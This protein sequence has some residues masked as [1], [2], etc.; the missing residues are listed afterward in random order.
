MNG[1]IRSLLNLLPYGGGGDKIFIFIMFIYANRRLPRRSSCLAN[2]YFYFLKNSSDI[3]DAYRQL[4]SDKILVKE[5]IEERVDSKFIVKTLGIF[6]SIDQ[7]DVR[8]LSKP[9]VLKPAH[10]SGSVVFIKEG[11]TAF[12]P[13]DRK[14]LV[15][16]L[17]SS[18]Y[19]EAR[20]A[21]YRY[22]R[23]R[24]ICEPM[25]SEGEKIK[26]YKIFC[27]RGEPRLI[28]VDSDRHSDHK[29]NIYTTN[30]TPLDVTYN[31]PT[32]RWETAP[33]CLSEMLRVAR[34]LSG[35][36]EFVRVDFFI[37]GSDLYVGELT[38]CPESAHGRF[39]HR[40]DEALF[41]KI[42]FFGDHTK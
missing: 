10:S 2:D 34:V 18:P 28:Q 4:T 40:S 23:A 31:F 7:I 39:K 14:K 15:K 9:C 38:H 8:S 25:L 11:Q 17:Q 26:D 16:S 6:D 19:K 33:S 22:L 21:N 29:R 3:L 36:F 24:I 41:S 35:Q 1:V 27:F 32:G 30:W 42:L 5:F 20:E 12:S 13:V 37:D